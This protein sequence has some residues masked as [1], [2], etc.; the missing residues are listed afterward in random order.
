MKMGK[1]LDVLSDGD[2]RRAL[3]KEDFS[4]DCNVEDIATLIQETLKNKEVIGK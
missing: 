3:M 1:F 2:L 4:M